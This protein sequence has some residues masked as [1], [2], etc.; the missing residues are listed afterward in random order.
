MQHNED[1]IYLSLNYRIIRGLQVKIWAEFIRKGGDGVVDDQYTRPSQ[2]FLFGLRNN[3]TNWGFNAKEARKNPVNVAV[4][5]W[6]C[7]FEG[8]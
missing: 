1:Q 6:M 7:L 4:N 8:D 5:R 3:Y 2:P